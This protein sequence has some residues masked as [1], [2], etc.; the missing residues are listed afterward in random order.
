MKKT[1]IAPAT[2]VQLMDVEN[3]LA[4]SAF[5]EN[6]NSGSTALSRDEEF[7]DDDEAWGSF[8]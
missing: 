3:M 6:A 2:K 7:F 5:N 8:E 1:Y 4:L